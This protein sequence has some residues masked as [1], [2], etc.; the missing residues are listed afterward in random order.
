MDAGRTVESPESETKGLITVRAFS[1]I[2]TGQCKEGYVTATH[3]LS[4]LYYREKPGLREPESF[5]M[6]VSRTSL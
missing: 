6:V 4:G 3:A 1:Y 5:I 2:P